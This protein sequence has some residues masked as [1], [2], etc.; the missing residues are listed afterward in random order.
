MGSWW[1]ISTILEKK[2]KPQVK[3]HSVFSKG[4]TNIGS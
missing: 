1:Q 4:Y 3:S 2:I